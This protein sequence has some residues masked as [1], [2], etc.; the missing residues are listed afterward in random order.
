MLVLVSGLDCGTVPAEKSEDIGKQPGKLT[1]QGKPGVVLSHGRLKAKGQPS[2]T[3][4]GL[5]ALP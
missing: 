4:R 2:A 3:C 5:S 1:R